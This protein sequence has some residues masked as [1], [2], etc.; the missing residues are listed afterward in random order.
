MAH[1]E[2]TVGPEVL[3]LQRLGGVVATH[4]LGGT[5]NNKKI[6]LVHMVMDEKETDVEVTSSFARAGL[7]FLLKNN[8][9]LVVLID[10]VLLNINTLGL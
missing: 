8:G 7:S 2:C 4:V 10:N 1:K 6:A 3:S 5:K 9:R